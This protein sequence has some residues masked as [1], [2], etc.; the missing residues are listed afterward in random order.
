MSFLSV[1]AV[2]AGCTSNT[3]VT[4]RSVA[5]PIP[6]LKPGVY[7]IDAVDVRP[8]ATREVEPDYPRELAAVLGGTAVVLLT[9]HT[10][11]KVVDTSVVKADDVLFGEAAIAAVEKWRFHPAQVNGAPVDCRMTLPFYFS[12]PYGIGQMDGAAAFPSRQK[13]ADSIA[14]PPAPASGTVRTSNGP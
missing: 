7:S 14:P 4:E 10:D 1:C 12:S 9:V 3:E 2:L 8:Q 6:P 5:N 13:P 11:G